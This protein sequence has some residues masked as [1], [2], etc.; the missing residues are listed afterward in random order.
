MQKIERM[1]RDIIKKS[2]ELKMEIKNKDIE[3]L[4]KRT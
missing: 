4:I 2:K 3:E 1:E